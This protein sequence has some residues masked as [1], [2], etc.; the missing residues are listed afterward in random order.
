MFILPVMK[1]HLTWETTK[2]GGRF[3]QVSLYIVMCDYNVLHYID[4]DITYSIS[5]TA[6]EQVSLENNPYTGK[7]V[8]ILREPIDYIVIC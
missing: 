3:I 6:T 2:F 7:Q 4:L 5:K 1:D 8:F